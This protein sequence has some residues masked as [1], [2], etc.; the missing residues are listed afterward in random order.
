VA[1]QRA[2]GT[3][4]GNGYAAMALL[5]SN[6]DGILSAADAN[7][8]KLQLWVDANVDA[9][10]DAGELHS[11]AEF[12]VVSLDLKGL[13]G[14]EVDHGNLLGLVSSYTGADGT[15]HAMADV[16]FAKDS[17]VQ[18]AAPRLD[19]LLVAPAAELLPSWHASGAA[20]GGTT[21]PSAAALA[22]AGIDR[23]LLPIDDNRHQPLI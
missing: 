22:P 4:A 21:T 6:G 19:E 17:T 13:V 7:F 9:K 15:Q 3:R 20:A 1:T 8:A 16:W 14:T 11:L 2:D 12:G 5:D 18:A 23:S 10:T